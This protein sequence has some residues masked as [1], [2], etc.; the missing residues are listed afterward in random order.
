MSIVNYLIAD[1]N[2]LYDDA[3]ANTASNN[4]GWVLVKGSVIRISDSRTISGSTADGFTGEICWDGDYIYVCV[5][6]N[7]WKRTS[8][9]TW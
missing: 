7:T 5:A 1:P 9:A 4:A 3:S 6:S 8:L 2:A